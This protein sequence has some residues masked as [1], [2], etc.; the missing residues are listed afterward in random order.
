MSLSL[1]TAT[2]FGAY[3]ASTADTGSDS[4][5]EPQLS[6][7]SGDIIFTPDIDRGLVEAAELSG[8][9]IG[10]VAAPIPARLQSGVLV[11]NLGVT[12]VTLHT[13]TERPLVYSVEFQ[14]VRYGSDNTP[15]PG[16]IKKFKFQLFADPD[17]TNLPEVHPYTSSSEAAAPSVAIINAD[18]AIQAASDAEDAAEAAELHAQTATTQAG[19]A[20]ERAG[21]AD[22]AADAA[23]LSRT[24]AKT[25]EDNA[26]L[27]EIAA[28]TSADDADTSENN[29]L[30][31]RNDAETFANTA[32][33]QAG[34]ATT[35]A[36]EAATSA[37]AAQTASGQAQGFRDQAALSAA[38][39]VRRINRGGQEIG[40]MEDGRPYLLD[41]EAVEEIP[42][43]VDTSVGT[44]AFLGSTMLFGD[45]GWRSLPIPEMTTGTYLMRRV[46]PTVHIQFLGCQFSHG[47]VSTPLPRIDVIGL[48]PAY[49]VRAVWTLTQSGGVGGTINI[50]DA[51]YVNMYQLTPT[52]E[53]WAC[54]SYIAKPEWPASLP[55]TPI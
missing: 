4:D 47:T 2:V 9:P 50:S 41:A 20:T 44:R 16:G 8:V 54:F 39:L 28:A 37:D 21:D 17:R 53:V 38:T 42:L 52:S 5:T 3:Y 1:T 7:L 55:G 19:I 29:A 25:S 6:P 30:L 51:G 13:F 14:N 22:D 49:R 40:Y 15:L 33:A 24:Q 27:S 32:E 11:D 48:R 46:G 34:I 18:R 43:E 10:L 35:K 36:G 26:K 31:H 12:D 23:A 45:T